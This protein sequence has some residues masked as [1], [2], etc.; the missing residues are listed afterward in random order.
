MS[1]YINAIYLSKDVYLHSNVTNRFAMMNKVTI[2]L[3]ENQDI[4]LPALD[5]ILGVWSAARDSRNDNRYLTSQDVIDI[6][7]LVDES[8]KLGPR[9]VAFASE[10]GFYDTETA[11]RYAEL[12]AR[13]ISEGVL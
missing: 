11:K 13:A 7:H 12:G 8:P 1:A 3:M 2:P 4:I 10:R 9:L 6:A 5:T